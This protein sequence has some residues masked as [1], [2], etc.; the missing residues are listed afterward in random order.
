MIAHPNIAINIAED[1]RA[2]ALENPLVRTPHLTA[3]RA[4]GVT[5]G[6]NYARSAE[7]EELYD[8]KNDPQELYNRID[9]P[10]LSEVRNDLRKCL[11]HWEHERSI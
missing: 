10:A 5:F 1:L 2:D 3:L 7:K 8:L 4:D 6:Q 11:L 9:A